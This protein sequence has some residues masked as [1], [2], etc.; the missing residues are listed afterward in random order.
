MDR[1]WR[2]WYSAEA[3]LSHNA[4]WSK[5][6]LLN[7]YLRY[8]SLQMRTKSDWFYF[9]RWV[10]LHLSVCVNQWASPDSIVDKKGQQEAQGYPLLTGCL[11]RAEEAAPESGLMVEMDAQS[12]R[13]VIPFMA[14][15]HLWYMERGQMPARE[16]FGHR[17][18][19]TDSSGWCG[20]RV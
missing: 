6:L 4:S 2:T 1:G 19:W 11:W 5:I 7:T 20:G 10:C 3:N 15:A 8:K 17:G 12:P 14:K 18:D 16:A 13:G 9:S